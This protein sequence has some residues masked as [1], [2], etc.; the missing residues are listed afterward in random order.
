LCLLSRA[1]ISWCRA[2]VKITRLLDPGWRNFNNCAHDKPFSPL[3]VFFR[4]DF[5]FGRMRGR[6][7]HEFFAPD[8]SPNARADGPE[9]TTAAIAGVPR[10]VD[11][12]LLHGIYRVAR[13]PDRRRR[14]ARARVCPGARRYRFGHVYRRDSLARSARRQTIFQSRPRESELQ[15]AGGE[16]IVLIDFAVKQG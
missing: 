2:R 14:G 9:T 11:A 16:K 8:A 6:R 1:E 13:G 12:A 7:T 15:D 10:P 4:S 5:V 3:V